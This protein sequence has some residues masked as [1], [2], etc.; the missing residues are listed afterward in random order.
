MICGYATAVALTRWALSMKVSSLIELQIF[1]H[2]DTY[3]GRK[4]GID[5]RDGCQN[6]L[7]AVSLR[8]G[9][10]WGWGEAGGVA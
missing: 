7:L 4:A 5:D 3:C 10:G 9:G 6:E 8:W 1:D 2:Y